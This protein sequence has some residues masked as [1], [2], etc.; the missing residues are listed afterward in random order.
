MTLRQ[1]RIRRR[2]ISLGANVNGGAARVRKVLGVAHGVLWLSGAAA[3]VAYIVY[4]WNDQS[5]RGGHFGGIGVIVVLAIAA[6]LAV[7]VL[8][9]TILGTLF[10]AAALWP[11]RLRRFALSPR[12]SLL[13]MGVFAGIVVVALGYYFGEVVAVRG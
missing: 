8:G 6:V 2:S 4:L 9:F 7:P 1:S 5:G 13:G 11:V 3:L 12:G 10:V